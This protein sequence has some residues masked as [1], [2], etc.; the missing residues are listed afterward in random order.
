MSLLPWM[1]LGASPTFS[2]NIDR[3]LVFQEL[4][5]AYAFHESVAGGGATPAWRAGLEGCMGGRIVHRK[6]QAGACNP[7]ENSGV[8]MYTSTQSS[9][10]SSPASASLFITR[11]I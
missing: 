1:T 6:A 5:V 4:N 10:A 9:A 11:S 3:S 7:E 2:L 8:I